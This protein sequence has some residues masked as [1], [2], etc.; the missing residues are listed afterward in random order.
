MNG[1][2][3]R[4]NLTVR[5]GFKKKAAELA[6]KRRRS[7]SALFEDLIDQEELRGGP[8]AMEEAGHYGRKKK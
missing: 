6:T 3:K 8:R 4:L 5:D 7:I 1:N 2:K